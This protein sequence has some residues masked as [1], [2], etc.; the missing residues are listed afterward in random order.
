MVFGGYLI[1]LFGSLKTHLT[2]WTCGQ[3]GKSLI[4][5]C[6]DG[7]I[8]AHAPQSGKPQYVIHSAHQTA[9]LALAVGPDGKTI[10]SGDSQGFVR[11]WRVGAS[12][13]TMLVSLKEHK[14][15]HSRGTVHLS[16][17]LYSQEVC[18]TSWT[19]LTCCKLPSVFHEECEQ[20]CCCSSTRAPSTG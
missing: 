7:T 14:V 5:G 12:S 20:L 19:C 8:R 16:P 13:Q 18:K 17:L 4:A 6:S 15:S 3:D 10:V 9:V 1:P 2:F 11:V